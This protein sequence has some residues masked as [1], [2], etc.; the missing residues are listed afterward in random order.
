MGFPVPWA[1]ETTSTII[2][3]K[4]LK[5]VYSENDFNNMLLNLI[6]IDVSNYEISR[7]K[8][9]GESNEWIISQHHSFIITELFH[10]THSFT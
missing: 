6:G 10:L 9:G 7:N 3:I 5:N 1:S 2:N 4:K 8:L